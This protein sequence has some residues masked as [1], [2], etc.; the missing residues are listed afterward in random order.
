MSDTP[1]NWAGRTF[2]ELTADEKRRVIKAAGEQLS[3]ELTASADVISAIL[4]EARFT[5]REVDEELAALYEQ[6]ARIDTHR[7]S[8][9]DTLYRMAGYRPLRGYGRQATWKRTT[10]EMLEDITGLI[11]RGDERNLSHGKRPSETLAAY[12]QLVAEIAQVM[13]RIGE[14][15]VIYKADPWSRF[16]PCTNANGH[17]HSSLSCS[18]CRW[19]TPMAWMPQLSGKTEAEA[20]NELGP[21]L[22]SVCFPSAPVE[23]RQDPK[24]VTTPEKA[25]REDAKREREAKKAAKTLTDEEAFEVVRDSRFRDPVRT[26]AACLEVLRTEVEFRDYY[27]N[28]EHS[29]HAGYVTAAGQATKVLLA[30]EAAHPGWGR[31]QEQI[32]KI[33]ANAVKKTRAEGARI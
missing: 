15:D 6:A 18:T 2:G 1:V 25:A 26:V 3:A 28:G 31:T 33:I 30:R 10:A 21:I 9:R 27:G 16:F 14:L 7:V 22:C 5:P 32:D 24:D 23:W 8:A 4:D 17:I 19:D 29:W 13:L 11:S 12:N 20:V